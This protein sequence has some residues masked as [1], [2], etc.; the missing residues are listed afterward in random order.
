MVSVLRTL[1]TLVVV[2]TACA[3][4]LLPG[5]SE[6]EPD[7]ECSVDQIDFPVVQSREDTLTAEF[8]IRNTGDGDNLSWRLEN[9]PEFGLRVLES[10]LYSLDEGEEV[11]YTLQFAPQDSI[12]PTVIDY[13]VGID[14]CVIRVGVEAFAPLIPGACCTD[15][16]CVDGVLPQECEGELDG[17][18]QGPNTTCADV[19]CPPPI[20]A[21]STDSLGWVS[22]I[23]DLVAGNTV[24]ETVWVAN[25]GG[26][27]MNGRF[28]L[29]GCSGPTVQLRGQTPSDP[30]DFSV[31]PGDTV[32]AEVVLTAGTYDCI[33]SITSDAPGDSSCSDVRVTGVLQFE[34]SNGQRR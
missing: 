20:C 12:G 25:V 9:L 3:L 29:P 26:T 8:T 18:F 10:P 4:A 27:I 7:C 11:T 1:P 16:G 13:R 24:T 17:T 31:L 6:G 23:D 32:Y 15:S 28:A 33:L 5:C 30:L 21:V 19:T 14:E 34:P 2:A 22:T